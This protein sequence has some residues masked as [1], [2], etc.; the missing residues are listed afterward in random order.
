M[1]E[2]IIAYSLSASLARCLKTRSQTPALA[3]RVKRAGKA[4]MNRFPV[5]EAL[6]QVPPGH[7]GPIS[8]QNCLNEQTI[9]CGGHAHM[10]QP[11]RQQI[12]DPLPFVVVQSVA[13]HRPALLEAD[14][15]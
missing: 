7:A 4:R 3:Q 1:V 13:A 12:L 8:V 9:V 6:R 15:P 14:R 10:A 11:P 5:S 2:S